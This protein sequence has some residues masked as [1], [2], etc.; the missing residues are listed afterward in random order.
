[1]PDT[2]RTRAALLALMADN[3]VGNVSA[4]D[5]RD[6]M[7]TVMES[8]FVNPGDFWTQPS[9]GNHTTDKTVKGWVKYSQVCISEI[10]FGRVMVMLSTGSGWVPASAGTA[11]YGRGMLG[12]AANSYA[13]AE[14][15]AQILM[16]G[17]VY[18]SA[19][20]ARFTG[21]IGNYIY[22]QS[23]GIGSVSITPATGS[24]HVVGY[25]E[26]S[27]FGDNTSGHWRFD[28]TWGVVAG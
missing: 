16:R 9:V 5:F 10:S 15:Q 26:L 23:T 22:L 19:L 17:L 7:V 21:N 8:D 28:P 6:F 2:Q 13:A 4:Q 25:V 1:M 18:D 20:S 27:A 3:A 14:S 11:P 24:I 12:I